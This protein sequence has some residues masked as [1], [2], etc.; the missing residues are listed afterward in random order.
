MHDMITNSIYL[1]EPVLIDSFF[2]FGYVQSILLS[3]FT[4][5]FDVPVLLMRVLCADTLVVDT[6]GYDVDVRMLLVEVTNCNKWVVIVAHALKV[7]IDYMLHLL[8]SK[9]INIFR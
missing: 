1:A 7:V 9:I 8:V 2:T 3:Q 5:D 6:A 4:T